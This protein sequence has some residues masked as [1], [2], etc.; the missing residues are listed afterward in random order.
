[1]DTEISENMQ[2]NVAD[3]LTLRNVVMLGLYS[4]GEMLDIFEKLNRL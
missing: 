1:M 2:N 4:K 3:S